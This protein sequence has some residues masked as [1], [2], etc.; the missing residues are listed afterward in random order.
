MTKLRKIDWVTLPL[1]KVSTLLIKGTRTSP[2]THLNVN[3]RKFLHN[4][5]RSKEVQ[6]KSTVSLLRR[7]ITKTGRNPQREPPSVVGVCTYI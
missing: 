7:L 4:H 1:R 6:V 5:C 2:P 3:V